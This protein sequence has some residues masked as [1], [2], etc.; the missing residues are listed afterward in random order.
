VEISPISRK[1]LSEQVAESIRNAILSGE[2]A[3]GDR[4]PSER[5]LAERFGVNRSSIRE[6]LGR[7]QALGLVGTRQGGGIVVRD[8][9]ADGGLAMLPY[10]LAPSGATD[11]HMFADVLEVRAV[12]CAYLARLAAHRAKAADLV[13]LREIL[14]GL[15]AAQTPFERQRLDF[16]F[17]RALA[18]ATGNRVLILVLNAIRQ[19]YLENAVLFEA[20]YTDA[21]FDT[22]RHQRVVATVIDRDGAAAAREV[23][24]WMERDLQLMEPLRSTSDA[25]DSEE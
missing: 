18:N 12:F 10:L 23:L 19:V 24:G 20:L 17:F 2:L 1:N 9:L 13:S 16:E 14:T 8:F 21:L 5:E 15:E 22:A 4:L 3:P 25:I 11:P 7:L 6:A